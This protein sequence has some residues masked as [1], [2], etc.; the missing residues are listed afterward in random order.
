MEAVKYFDW[1]LDPLG[2]SRKNIGEPSYRDG[3][4][5]D[6]WRFK[7]CEHFHLKGGELWVDAEGVGDFSSV[8]FGAFELPF[9][10]PSLASSISAVVGDQVQWVPVRVRNTGEKL[11]ILNA[12]REIK[13]IDE[14]RSV[15]EKWKPGNSGRPDKVGQYKWIADLAIDDSMIGNSDV[16][17][18][19]GWRMALIVSRRVKL[20]AE[21]AGVASASFTAVA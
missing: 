9:F 11:Y 14:S 21:A 12:L 8:T 10:L 20:I 5:I 13:C 16:F 3:V 1:S 4:R 7:S 17:R 15:F 6:A 2:T 18:P 19:W